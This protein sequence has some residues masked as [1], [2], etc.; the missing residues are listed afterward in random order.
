MRSRFQENIQRFIA[1]FFIVLLG[2]L[3]VSCSKRGRIQPEAES[4]MEQ[5]PIT[6]KGQ[7]STTSGQ[8]VEPHAEA[9]NKKTVGEEEL[10]TTTLSTG[11]VA[12]GSVMLSNKP[13]ALLQDLFFDYD[14]FTIRST[15]ITVLQQNAAWLLANPNKAIVI[16]GHADQRGTN[17]YNLVL[18]EKRAK[19]VYQYLVQL[20]LPPSQILVNSFGEERPFCKTKDETCLQENRRAH[21]RIR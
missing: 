10:A 19:A 17:E 14:Q 4:G 20:G 6:E 15:D 5:A 13:V 7:P 18:G 16:D 9:G 21:F 1:G 11:T 2:L 8:P 3:P 12:T